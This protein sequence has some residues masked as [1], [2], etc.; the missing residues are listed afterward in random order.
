[1]ARQILRVGHLAARHQF[2]G[3][4]LAWLALPWLALPSE[5]LLGGVEIRAGVPVPSLVF[6]VPA[7]ALLAGAGLAAVRLVMRLLRQR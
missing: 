2:P 3:R 5:L 4:L 6:C 7:V 1:M